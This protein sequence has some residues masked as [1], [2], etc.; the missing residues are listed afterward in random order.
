MTDLEEQH[1]ISWSLE[2]WDLYKQ[3]FA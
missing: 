2:T 1:S 3:Y